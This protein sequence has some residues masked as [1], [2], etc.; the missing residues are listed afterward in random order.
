MHVEESCLPDPGRAGPARGLRRTCD[1]IR[2]A[3]AL[4]DGWRGLPDGVTR[5]RLAA[6]V[7]MA[8]RRLELTA[9]TLRLL[10]HYIDLSYDQDWGADSEPVIYRPLFEIAEHMGVSERQVRNL[11]R[12]LCELGLLAFRDSGNHH[13]RGRRDRRT[14]KLTYAYGPSL[15]PLGARAAEILSLAASARHMIAENRRLRFAASALRRRIC[16]DLQAADAAGKRNDA[17]H[18]AFNAL[19]RRTPAGVTEAAL[20]QLN[21]ELASLA[22][23]ARAALDHDSAAETSTNHTGKAEISCPHL[24]DTSNN[25][26]INGVYVNDEKYQFITNRSNLINNSKTKRSTPT[27]HGISRIPLKVALE[28][29]ERYGMITSS[30]YQAHS[31]NELTDM[32]RDYITTIGVNQTLWGDACNKLGRNG[33]TLAAIIVISGMHRSKICKYRPIKNTSAY[34]NELVRRAMIGQLRIDLSIWAMASN[35]P[36]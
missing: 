3:S 34:F 5:W 36:I 8:A 28:V 27:D 29:V 16:A 7:R 32:V 1:A 30:S 6:A 19:P 20:R 33:A 23:A 35:Q 12:R 10:E 25:N 18:K 15:A 17:L 14:G 4:A 13:R 22:N 26:S 9:A 31:W 21:D 2:K 11:E 24:N